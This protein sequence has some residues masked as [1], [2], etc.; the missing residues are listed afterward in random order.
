MTNPTTNE[1]G[2]YERIISK[3]HEEIG[4]T[5]DNIKKSV[6]KSSNPAYCLSIIASIREKYD[7]QVIPLLREGYLEDQSYREVYVSR[8]N[9]LHEVF[10]KAY[11]HAL[12]RVEELG[13][14]LDSSDLSL[15]TLPKSLEKII[16]PE[17]N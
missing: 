1:K 15:S 7:N 8:A 11:Q 12:K 13:V 3:I 14:P 2:F 5:L 16:F 9:Y 4:V 17:N 6:D 10:N